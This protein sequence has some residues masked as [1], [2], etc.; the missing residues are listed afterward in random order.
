MVLTRKQQRLKGDAVSAS[1]ETL[2]HDPIGEQQLGAN[3]TERLFFGGM[4]VAL[5]I[6]VF[7]GFA[8]TYY[9]RAQFDG[10]ALTP[11]LLVHGFLFSTWMVLLGVQTSLIAAGK[12]AVHR[13][14]GVAGAVLG[15]L[16]MFVGAYVA[17]TRAQAGLST[18]PPGMT[19]AVFLTLPLAT[20]LVFPVL[21]G[22]A[23]WQ[24]RR[25]DYHKRLIVVAT[26]ELVTAGVARWPGLTPLGPLAFFGVTD[27]FLV[28]L[29]VYDWRTLGR[30]HPATLWGGV[31]LLASQ[32]LRFAIGFTPPWEAFVSWLLT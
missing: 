1:S 29:A 31:F 28:A 19:M 24:R 10:P 9:L 6:A 20:M 17:I 8:P 23:L 32:P 18:P 25:T 27:L 16:M 30:I 26:L 3:R 15:V 22:A 5:L 4:A 21:L 14:L 7:V 11:P 13:K 2:R 12:T